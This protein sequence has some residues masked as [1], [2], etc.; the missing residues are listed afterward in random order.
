MKITIQ[1]EPTL[2]C[3][4]TSIGSGATWEE[5]SSQSKSKENKSKNIG[6][7]TCFSAGDAAAAEEGAVAAAEVSAFLFLVS[8]LVNAFEATAAG[9]GAPEAFF[10]ASG[11]EF[12]DLV[13]PAFG[14]FVGR[15]SSSSSSS[16]KRKDS[17]A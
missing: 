14:F 2:D 5:D 8:S 11:P 7:L 4:Q 3:L 15:T 10:N 9:S 6:L 16:L 13:D 1:I 12:T 17:S